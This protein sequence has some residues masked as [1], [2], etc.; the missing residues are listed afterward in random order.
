[1]DK[2]FYPDYPILIVDD[3]ANALLSLSTVLKMNGYSNIKTIRDEREVAA[4]MS[5]AP[6]CCVILDLL[7]P[8][9]PGC[10]LLDMIVSKHPEAPVI[11][12]TAHD[13]ATIA[14]DCMKK[15]AYDF[16]VKPIESSHLLSSIRRAIEIRELREEMSLRQSPPVGA[17][18]ETAETIGEM[19]SR[20]RK[21]LAAFDYIRSIAPSSMSVFITG[22]T[23][24][25]KELAA[26]AIHA[27]SGRTGPLVPVNVAGLDDVMFSD[28]LFG[29]LKG[30]YT[31]ADSS[32]SGL[33]AKAENGTLFLDEIGDMTLSSQI[34]LLRLIQER[35]FLPLGSDTHKKTNARIIASTNRSTQELLKSDNFRNDLYYRLK[36][37]HIHLPPLRERRDDIPL[38]LARFFSE[39]SEELGKSQPVVPDQ[40][41]ELL[42]TYNFPGNIREL[43]S[44]VFDAVGRHQKGVLSL[45]SFRRRI[46]NESG[47]TAIK[48]ST[49]PIQFGDRLP[50]LKEARQELITEAL[51]RSNNNLS[52]AAKMLGITRQSLSQ[53]VKRTDD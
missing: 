2:P 6:V 24:V 40:I 17:Q 9:I 33:I 3:E 1:M 29:H 43:R 46:A 20:N 50:T 16:I 15:G 28:T 25:G 34:K 13:E 4:F 5:N 47:R 38:L 48:D 36:T 44:L 53:Q 21:M 30:A 26:K 39:A 35:E 32:R 7:L 18:P 52:I 12:A 23:G 27:L 11:I 19:V 31:G 51:R 42:N 45:S 41:I 49:A 8:Y 37:H 14:V 10:D 22:E